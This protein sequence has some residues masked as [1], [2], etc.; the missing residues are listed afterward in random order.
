[1]VS[2][3]IGPTPSGDTSEGHPQ[4]TGTFPR[5]F[6]KLVRERDNLPLIQAVAKCTLLP[7]ETFGLTGK[8]R[9]MEGAD[10]DLVIWDL[11]RITDRADFPGI[12]RPDA[13]PEGIGYVIVN[14]RIVV[15]NNRILKGVLP[16]KTI[17]VKSTGNR[18]LSQAG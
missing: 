18:N 16:G 13:P 8:G 14:G 3:D 10:A 9:L 5:F 1:M 6:R 12:G 4:N 7:A 2:S 15:Q 17:Q 11:D